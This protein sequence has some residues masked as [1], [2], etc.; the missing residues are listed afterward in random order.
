MADNRPLWSV[1][2]IALLVKTGMECLSKGALLLQVWLLCPSYLGR[3][4][5]VTLKNLFNQQSRLGF[6]LQMCIQ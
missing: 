2:E 3:K 1:V 5:F 4:I 6:E